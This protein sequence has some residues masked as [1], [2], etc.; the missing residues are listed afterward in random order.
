MESGVPI[1]IGSVPNRMELDS[2]GYFVIYIDRNREIISMEHFS[3]DGVLDIIIEGKRGSEIYSSA[4]EKGLLSRLDHAAYL[5][6][7]LERAE[8]SLKMGVEYIQDAAPESMREAD[9]S[10]DFCG[11]SDC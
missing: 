1:Q 11:F 3:V 9:R 2:S 5:G 4:I 7:E 8:R 6:K 10:R